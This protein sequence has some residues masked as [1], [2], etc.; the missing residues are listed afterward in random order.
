[1]INISAEGTLRRSIIAKYILLGD[2][3]SDLF[4]VFVYVFFCIDMILKHIFRNVLSRP[5]MQISSLFCLNNSPM[6]SEFNLEI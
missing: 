3:N 6:Y 5:K 4:D 1:M 2:L